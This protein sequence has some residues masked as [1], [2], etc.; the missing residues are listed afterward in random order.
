[1]KLSWLTWLRW[2]AALIVIYYHLNQIR[3][4]VWLSEWS[5]DIYQFT[6][7]LVF[8]VSFFF[9][10]SGLF[11]SLPYWRALLQWRDIPEFFPSL[12]DRFF[13]IA[14]AYYL[15][16]IV[17]FI[18]MILWQG[19]WWTDVLRLFSGLTFLSWI[20]PETFFPVEINGPLWFISYDMMGWILTSLVMMGIVKIMKSYSLRFSPTKQWQKLIISLL[21]LLW[22]SGALLLLHYTWI[23]LPWSPWEA[24]TGVWF[25]IYNPFL[26]GLHFLLGAIV[27]G[28]IVY[29]QE[30]KPRVVYDI[31]VISIFVVLIGFLWNIRTLEDWDYSWPHGPYHFP[32]VPLLLAGVLATLPFTRYVGKYIDNKFLTWIATLSYSLYLFHM[33][34][35]SILRR[36]FFIN[37]QLWFYNWSIFSILTLFLSISIAWIVWKYVESRE[38]ITKSKW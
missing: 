35:I 6:E 36:Y 34:V 21:C 3:S 28:V 26:F 38:W 27:G 17:S 2:L 14:P 30:A 22:I 29:F 31:F 16:L 8:V 7:H 4:T 12:R 37:E 20:S 11:R 9:M 13:R 5:W 15:A 1:M 18:C 10:T 23:A 33:L 24:I 19:V 25:P 32:I